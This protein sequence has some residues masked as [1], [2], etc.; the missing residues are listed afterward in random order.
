MIALGYIDKSVAG[1]GSHGLDICFQ[2]PSDVGS[3]VSLGQT[4]ETTDSDDSDDDDDADF[5][6]NGDNGY[7]D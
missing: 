5:D 4:P 1:C 2:F 6:D 7:N 3:A